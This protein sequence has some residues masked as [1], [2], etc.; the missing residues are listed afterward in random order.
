MWEIRRLKALGCPIKDLIDVVKQQIVSVCEFGVPYWAPM[1]TKVESKKI[2]ACLKPR[3]FQP[4]L[5]NIPIK[6]RSDFHK[7]YFLVELSVFDRLS[8]PHQQVVSRWRPFGE[9]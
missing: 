6:Y 8:D 2:E 1:I 9:L 3:E 4:R 5:M 7:V